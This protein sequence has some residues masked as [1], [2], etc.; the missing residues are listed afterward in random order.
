MTISIRLFFFFF[1]LFL[2]LPRRVSMRFAAGFHGGSNH[3]LPDSVGTNGIF[4]ERPHVPC[5]LKYFAFSAHMLP[6]VATCCHIL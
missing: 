3:R 1:L 5:I 6:Y 2:L 4:T